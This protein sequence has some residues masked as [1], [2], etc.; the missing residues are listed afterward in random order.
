MDP[1][2]PM[3][4]RLTYDVWS[5]E[6]SPADCPCRCRAAPAKKAVLSIVPGTSNSRVS[7]SGFPHWSD[8]ARARS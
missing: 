6:Y 7:F 3:G 1:T 2:T 4:S 5:P 8:S